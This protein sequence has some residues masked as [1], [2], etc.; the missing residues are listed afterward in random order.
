VHAEATASIAGNYIDDSN[1]DLAL[2]SGE[3]KLQTSMAEDIAR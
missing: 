2:G 1:L 3:L